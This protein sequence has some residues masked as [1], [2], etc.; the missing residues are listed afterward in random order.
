MTNIHVYVGLRQTDSHKRRS[1]H[2]DEDDACLNR[3]WINEN[4]PC[5]NIIW[6]DEKI[7]SVGIDAEVM[8]Q[9]QNNGLGK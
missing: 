2:I 1:S 3:S 9:W 7:V 8:P 6:N 5:S 4:N